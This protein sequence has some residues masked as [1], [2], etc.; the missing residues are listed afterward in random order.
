MEQTV[1]KTKMEEVT[2]KFGKGCVGEPFTGS[3][4]VA[5]T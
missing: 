1:E 5:V 2:L 4:P 3:F